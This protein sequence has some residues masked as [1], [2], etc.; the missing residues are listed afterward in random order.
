MKQDVSRR[1][2]VKGTAG[3]AGVI[4]YI[5]LATLGFIASVW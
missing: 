5:A 1:E 4:A 2:F 3:L